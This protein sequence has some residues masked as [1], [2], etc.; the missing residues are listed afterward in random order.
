[1]KSSDA[2]KNKSGTKV[3]LTYLAEA[4]SLCKMKTIS[5][6]D[7]TWLAWEHGNDE[8]DLT[9]V[10]KEFLD[11]GRWASNYLVV[12]EQKGK[13]WG[14]DYADPATELQEGMDALDR[15]IDYND[16]EKTVGVL[17]VKAEQVTVTKYSIK[18]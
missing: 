12:F 16:E 5:V 17:P 1:M 7:A 18:D 11:N 4:D 14:F 15:F 3:Q 8:A 9:F 6:D 13:L 2:T 10:A